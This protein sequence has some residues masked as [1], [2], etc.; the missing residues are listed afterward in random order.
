M[1][2]KSC[3]PTN[4]TETVSVSLFSL[5]LI[6]FFSV[7]LLHWPK[8]QLHKHRADFVTLLLQNDG[9]HCQQNITQRVFFFFFPACLFRLSDSSPKTD[10]LI[11]GSVELIWTFT[12]P[13]CS[14]P[15]CALGHSLHGINAIPFSS[16]SVLILSRS[17]WDVLSLWSLLWTH[18]PTPSLIRRNKHCFIFIPLE[19]CLCTSLSHY[20]PLLHKQLQDRRHIFPHF[21]H[22]IRCE[23]TSFHRVSAQ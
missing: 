12:A 16:P 15:L 4:F 11:H 1:L 13:S 18:R 21:L 6:S 17:I 5:L 7:S 19:T 10:I 9:T 23:Q 22:P 3:S 20:S 2:Q 14:D 8:R